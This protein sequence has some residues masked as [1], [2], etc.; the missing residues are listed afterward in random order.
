MSAGRVLR[1]MTH[2]HRRALPLGTRDA[3]PRICEWLAG[4]TFDPQPEP[5]GLV[6]VRLD[7][8]PHPKRFCLPS[9]R[10]WFGP[11]ARSARRRSAPTLPGL[12]ERWRGVT[13]SLCSPS[14]FE[15][16][17]AHDGRATG[18]RVAV[19]PVSENPS[20]LMGRQSLGWRPR[21]RRNSTTAACR[22]WR[23]SLRPNRS[24]PSLPSGENSSD[25]LLLLRDP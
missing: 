14:K 16:C 6:L 13:F 1:R 21:G 2:D 9:P 12:L 5:G 20:L 19:S 24:P 11:A 22:S 15:R 8:H 7:V 18:H 25:D 10:S 23:V 17:R 3:P 4:Y